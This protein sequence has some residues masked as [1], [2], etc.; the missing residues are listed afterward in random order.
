MDAKS[1]LPC[2]AKKGVAFRSRGIRKREIRD[3][4]GN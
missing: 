1:V 3:G 2:L 4:C